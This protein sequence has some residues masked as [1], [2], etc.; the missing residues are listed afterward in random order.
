[1]ICVAPGYAQVCDKDAWKAPAKDDVCAKAEV[2][3][4][5]T[6]LNQCIYHDVR[7][8]VGAKI[9]VGPN[10]GLTCKNDGW[11]DGDHN[12][13]KTCEHAQIPAPTYPASPDKSTTAGK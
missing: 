11:T 7:Y 5:G 8:A 3:V 4:P 6:F 12:L 13:H 2:A 1:M 9:C 10:F